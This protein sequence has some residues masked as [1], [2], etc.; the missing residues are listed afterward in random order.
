M[1]QALVLVSA[2]W[3]SQAGS[4]YGTIDQGGSR[5]A[6]AVVSLVGGDLKSKPLSGVTIDQ[7]GKKFEPHVTAITPGTT[8]FF[9]NNDTVYHNV[10]AHYDAARFDLGVYPRGAVKK[11]T[12]NKIGVVSLLCSMH[13][14]MNAY[15]VVVD[16]PYL[17]VTKSDGKFS[18]EGVPSGSYTLNVWHESGA[19]ATKSI[20]IAGGAL[21]TSL[22]LSMRQ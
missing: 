22:S 11:K 19:K 1:I 2:A 6:N 20:T 12:F 16:S 9:P 21:Q 8:V 4:V 10:F 14:E 15:I 17:Q 3:T 7:R 18:F 5:I 13:S